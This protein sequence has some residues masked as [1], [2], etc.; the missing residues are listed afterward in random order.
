MPIICLFC[1][2]T[3]TLQT[4]NPW[5]YEGE[6]I[7]EPWAVINVCN[8]HRQNMTKVM[9]EK[10]KL[11]SLKKISNIG[12]VKRKYPHIAWNSIYGYLK[13]RHKDYEV[14]G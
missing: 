8:H 13:Y 7:N 6:R 5:E 9:T 3:R 4:V 12:E 2:D 1:Q 11:A 14:G 10:I